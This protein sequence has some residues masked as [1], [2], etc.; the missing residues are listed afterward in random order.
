MNKRIIL[1]FGKQCN[2]NCP[3]CYGYFD[4]KDLDLDIISR[5]VSICADKD[6]KKISVAGGDPLDYQYIDKVVKLAIKE[7]L[8][9]DL[10]SNCWSYSEKKHKE[11][12]KNVD[13]LGIPIDGDNADLHDS[14]RNK[15]G[16]FD[17]I[18]QVLKSVDCKVSVNTVVTKDNFNYLN[19][20]YSL[21][22]K[23]PIIKQW[24][25]YELLPLLVDDD[26]YMEQYVEHEL[27]CKFIDTLR[28]DKE[29]DIFCKP[30]IGRVTSH[31]FV[32]TG[33]DIY[34][35]DHEN[36]LCYKH[37]GSIFEVGNLN[38]MIKYVY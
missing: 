31:M 1:T 35:N 38:N 34:C 9:V 13:Y 33:G 23:F 2:M 25:V 22:K 5:I 3:F 18:M 36:P 12:L 15:K 29:I 14:I 4:G 30:K 11:I 7:G 27:Y 28:N 6:I 26:Y 37:F 19:E 21:I 10:D 20:I 16:S 8:S 24:H 17:K 32:S